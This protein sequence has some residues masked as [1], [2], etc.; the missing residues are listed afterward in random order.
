MTSEYRLRLRA[1]GLEMKPGLAGLRLSWSEVGAAHAAV[2]QAV[3]KCPSGS[4]PSEF[5]TRLAARLKKRKALN[6]AAIDK[7]E[8][9]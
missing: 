5:L 2:E 6:S 1:L 9:R 4:F 8:D 3:K 7:Q